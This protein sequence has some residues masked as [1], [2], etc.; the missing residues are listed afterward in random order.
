M[1]TDATSQQ[2]ERLSAEVQYLGRKGPISLGA[3]IGA[4]RGIGSYS[5]LEA[6]KNG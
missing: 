2:A 4:N 6:G 3:M 5:E 1:P